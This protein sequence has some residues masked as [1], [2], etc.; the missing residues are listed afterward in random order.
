MRDLENCGAGVYANLDTITITF[1]KDTD[2]AGL[3]QGVVQTRGTVDALFSF[4]QA[5]GSSYRGI[6]KTKRVFEITIL[7]WPGSAPPRVGPEGGSYC[8]CISLPPRFPRGGGSDA[9]F[10]MSKRRLDCDTSYGRGQ[11]ASHVMSLPSCCNLRSC[12]DS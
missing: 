11:V 3:A 4:D 1:D 10:S 12:C 5:L 6:W 7:D 8:E 2:K 9:A